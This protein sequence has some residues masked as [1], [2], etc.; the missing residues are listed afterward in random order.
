[1]TAN[2]T[3]CRAVAATCYEVGPLDGQA[4]IA[5][6]SELLTNEQLRAFARSLDPLAHDSTS[7]HQ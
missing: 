6:Q 5:V 2:R 7:A 1:M 3:A 4:R